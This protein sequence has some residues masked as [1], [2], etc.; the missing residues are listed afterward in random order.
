MTVLL[1]RLYSSSRTR[2]RPPPCVPFTRKSGPL[3]VPEDADDPQLRA[4]CPTQQISHGASRFR[5]DALMSVS[6]AAQRAA[7][8]SVSLEEGGWRVAM[9][10]A[11][12][13]GSR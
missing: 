2:A 5:R 12:R 3:E 10:Q 11:T 6:R 1:G 13:N 8:S 4:V 9:G 7:V